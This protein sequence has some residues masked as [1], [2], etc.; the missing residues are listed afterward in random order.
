MRIMKCVG[1]TYK[2]EEKGI[3]TKQDGIF[4]KLLAS[5]FPLSP[6]AFR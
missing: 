4:P 6:I 3:N 2:T 5:Q 1:G